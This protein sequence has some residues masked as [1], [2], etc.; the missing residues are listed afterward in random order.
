MSALIEP[1][2]AEDLARLRELSA[3]RDNLA[4]KLLSLELEKIPILA[5][6]RRVDEEHDGVLRRIMSER[7]IPISSTVNINP[8]TGEVVV[9]P[10]SSSASDASEAAG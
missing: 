3:A 4:H 1:V 5:A 6:G 7:G 9:V 10:P 2:G 8:Q